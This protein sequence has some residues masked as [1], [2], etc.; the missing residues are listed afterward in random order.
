VVLLRG[1]ILRRI[2]GIL[3]EIDTG[4]FRLEPRPACFWRDFTD[5]QTAQQKTRFV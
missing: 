5:H 2:S 1:R 4:A 3:E